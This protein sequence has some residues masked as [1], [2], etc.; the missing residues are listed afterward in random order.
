MTAREVVVP[1]TNG[2]EGFLHTDNGGRLRILWFI[3][4]PQNPPLP[5]SYF[6]DVYDEGLS[7]IQISEG[8]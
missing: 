7:A 8:Y 1:I 5:F 4:K 3:F 6:N 2:F